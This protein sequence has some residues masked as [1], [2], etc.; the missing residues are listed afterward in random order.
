MR[1]KFRGVLPDAI[2]FS[3][4]RWKGKNDPCIFLNHFTTFL[5]E[6]SPVDYMQRLAIIAT[7]L[8]PL[9]RDESFRNQSFLF[10]FIL[11][12]HQ[13]P[14]RYPLAL[15]LS[16]RARTRLFSICFSRVPEEW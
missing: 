6:I 16:L 12:F 10:R 7:K 4:V 15:F 1:S 9:L 3:C 5:Y 2:H 14:S 13:F 11:H 8:F